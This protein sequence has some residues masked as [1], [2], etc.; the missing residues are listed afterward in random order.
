MSGEVS[1]RVAAA[2][3]LAE[4]MSG[5]SLNVALPIHLQKTRLADRSLT[6]ELVYGSLRLWPRLDALVNVQLRKPLRSKDHDIF[7][8]I[9]LGLYQLSELRIPEHAAVSETVESARRMKKPWATGLIN[10]ILRHWMRN[11]ETLPSTLTEAEREALPPWLWQTLRAQWP[12]QAYSIAEASRHRPPMTLRVNQSKISVVDYLTAL[13]QQ[14]IT[15]RAGKAVASAIALDEGTDVNNLPGF[16][17]GLVSVQ[18]ASAQLAAMLLS[19]QPGETVL[20]ACA[21]PGG[22]TGHLFEL[23]SDITLLASDVSCDRLARIRENCERLQIPADIFQMDASRASEHFGQQQLDA[24][25]ADVP[26]SASGVMRRNP[27]VKLLRTAQDLLGFAAQQLAILSGLWPV[28]KPGGRILYVTCSLFREENDDVIMA[29]TKR[30][31]DALIQPIDAPDT[32]QTQF[33]LQCLPSVTGG[34]GLYFCLLRKNNV[35]AQ[36][37]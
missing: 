12:S 1:A 19:P 2:R 9:A 27:D 22:K 30:Q 20:D 4:V 33:G 35:D 37:G 23:A 8:L 7:C 32:H 29:F 15:A 5:K 16:T 13:E 10:G 34:D 11:E 6:Q 26:C 18:D 24:I 3:I 25:I 36:H 31:A 17:D 21:A 14:G 28:L